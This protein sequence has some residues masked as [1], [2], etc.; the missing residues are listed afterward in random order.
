MCVSVTHRGVFGGGVPAP[1]CMQRPGQGFK[2]LKAGVSGVCEVPACHMGARF[3]MIAQGTLL[4]T[5]PSLQTPSHV[6]AAAGRICEGLC[7][8]TPTY[9]Q[10]VW[11]TPYGRRNI[12]PLGTFPLSL[13]IKLT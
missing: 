11:G 13:I 8:Q 12:Y 6:L 4:T 3:L 9:T 7:T 2:Y 10:I 1:V 5:E